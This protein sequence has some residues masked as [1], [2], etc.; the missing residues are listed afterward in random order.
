MKAL[1]LAAGFGTRLAPHT[2]KLPK[3]LF[4]VAGTPV[5]GRMIAALK[6]AG[7]S[8]I[9]VNAHHLAHQIQ[10]YLSQNDFGLPVRLSP[11]PEILGTGG[12]IRQLADYWDEEPFIVIN[13]DII[14]NIDLADVYACHLK[15]GARV[16]LVMHDRKPFNQ[17]WV[18]DA[19]QIAGFERFSDHLSADARRRR[20]TSCPCGS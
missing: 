7:C 11:E 18:D 3:A 13:A 17:V 10:T 20:R 19:N 4:P 15:K 5:L 2:Q 14:T 1:I 16:T 6:Q 9:A 8:S 12:A